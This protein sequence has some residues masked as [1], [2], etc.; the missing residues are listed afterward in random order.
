MANQQT[1]EA[2]VHTYIH[3]TYYMITNANASTRA[4]HD[5]SEEQNIHS[6]AP[7]NKI[8]TNRFCHSKRNALENGVCCYCCLFFFSCFKVFS[9]PKSSNNSNNDNLKQKSE[10][11]TGKSVAQAVAPLLL[12]LSLPPSFIFRR[13]RCCCLFFCYVLQN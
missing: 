10:R 9:K 1:C 11:N 13:R 7:S 6:K 3:T 2:S 5:A 8:L 4:H 12:S